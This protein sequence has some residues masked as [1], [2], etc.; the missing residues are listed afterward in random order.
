MI[1]RHDQ[2]T[3]LLLVDG[4]MMMVMRTLTMN[5]ACGLTGNVVVTARSGMVVS[6]IDR[7]GAFTEVPGDLW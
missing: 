4:G 7:C 6:T 5:L 3:G 1:A 2:A